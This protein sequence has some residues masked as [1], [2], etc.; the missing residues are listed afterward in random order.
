MIRLEPRLG[1][2]VLWQTVKT[3]T[4]KEAFHQ[5][6]IRSASGLHC[7]LTKKAPQALHNTPPLLGILTYTTLTYFSTKHLVMCNVYTDV[8]G[9]K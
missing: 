8:G 7:L 9:I 6:C 4:Y 3:Q 1:N 2:Q 5:V